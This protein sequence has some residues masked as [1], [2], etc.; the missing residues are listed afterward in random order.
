MTRFLAY[1][2]HFLAIAVVFAMIAA[3]VLVSA[4]VTRAAVSCTGPAGMVIVG[5][6]VHGT[7]GADTINCSASTEWVEIRGNAGADILTGSAFADWLLGGWGGDTLNGGDG[8][9][10]LYGGWG[11]DTLNGNGGTDTCLGGQ[12]ADVNGDSCNTYDGGPG[13]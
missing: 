10:W 1:N 6:V 4:S 7:K 3:T 13:G 9:D 2:R 8:A 11:G 5:N 12:N